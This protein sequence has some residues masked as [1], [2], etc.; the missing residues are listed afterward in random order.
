VARDSLRSPGE[1]EGAGS[2]DPWALGVAVGNGF[3][4]Q[5]GMFGLYVSEGVGE[6][7][8]VGV[9]FGVGSGVGSGCGGTRGSGNR[10]S[11]APARVSDRF[12]SGPYAPAD[13][14]GSGVTATTAFCELA[15]EA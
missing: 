11:A 15:P 12:Q 5:I 9:A 4:R 10:G 2:A 14:V 1:P 13:C 7:T 8:G 3:W 6:A